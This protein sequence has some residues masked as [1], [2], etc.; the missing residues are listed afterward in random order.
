MVF[1]VLSKDSLDIE[2]QDRALRI[3]ARIFESCI[4]GAIL[5]TSCRNYTFWLDQI[6][7][8]RSRE[9]QTLRPGGRRKEA[10]AIATNY[11]TCSA[12]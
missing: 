2:D 11:N 4:N 8:C 7:V 9:P 5:V 10:Y 3:C 12:A 1:R 6:V